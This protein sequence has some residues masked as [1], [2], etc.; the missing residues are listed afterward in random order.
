MNIVILTNE[1]P[2]YVYGG[3]GVHVEYLSRA[4]ADLENRAHRVKILCFGDQRQ[5]AQNLTVEGV[6]PHFQ[7]PFQDPRH[8]RFLETL[9][10]DIVMA[11]SVADADVVHCHTWYSHLAGCLLRPLLGARLVLTTHSLEPHRPWKVEQL[12]SA[13]YASSWVER[14]AYENAD[15]VI[16][17][18]EAM[19]RDVQALYGVPSEKIRVIHNGIDI[20]QYRPRPNRAI[21]RSYDID[22]GVPFLLFVGR[23]TRQKGIIHLVE[24]IKYLR[25]GVQIVLCAGAPDTPEI[26]AEMAE[27]VEQARA[28]SPNRIIWVPQIVPREALISLYTHAAVFVCPSVYEPFG[29]INLEAMACETPVVASAVG[30]I[31]E[32]VVHGETGLLVPFEPVSA[33]DFDP[34]EPEQF[35]RDLAAAVNRLLDDPATMRQMSGNARARV[36]RYFSWTS[37]AQRTLE[38]YR[39]LASTGGDVRQ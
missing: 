30:G 3:A 23:I 33:H 5:Q 1:Y 8:Q 12:G 34:K 39:A 25:P 16:A 35:S 10:R 2:P 7:P 17:V 22:P 4:L 24:A 14:T 31:P 36:E 28:Q 18:S 15:G 37:V 29:I 9:I 26:G 19:R 32:V 20:D 11:G 21:L 27:H 38:F 13:Y 6:E